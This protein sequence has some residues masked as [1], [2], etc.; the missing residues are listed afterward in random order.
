MT[1]WVSILCG[2]KQRHPVAALAFC[3]PES[4]G[5]EH[6]SALLLKPLWDVRKP[7]ASPS[8]GLDYLLYQNFYGLSR[9]EKLLFKT[10]VPSKGWGGML[11]GCLLWSRDCYESLLALR[12]CM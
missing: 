1:P 5:Y 7:E 12:G 8:F 4:T 9:L 11:V 3:G 10:S 2:V 6:L